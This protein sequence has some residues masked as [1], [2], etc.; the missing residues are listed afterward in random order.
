[1]EVNTVART[2]IAALVLVVTPAVPGRSAPKA[3]RAGPDTADHEGVKALAQRLTE[4]EGQLAELT[5]PD[6]PRS[7]WV[8]CAAG[9]TVGS[10][11]A[12]AARTAGPLA[13]TIKGLCTEHVVITRDDTTLQGANPGDGLMS[14]EGK[15]PAPLVRV[16]GAQRTILQ[17]LALKPLAPDDGVELDRGAVVT[18]SR[19]VIDDAQHALLLGEATIAE[20]EDS[21]FSNSHASQVIVRGGHLRL[22]RSTIA[23]GAFTGVSVMGGGTLECGQNTLQGNAYW[24]LSVADNASAT[25]LEG[26]EIEENAVGVFVATGGTVLV[27]SGSLIGN[28][29]EEGIR[30]SEGSRLT[31]GGGVIVE[32]NAGHGVF[33]TGGSLVSAF[34]ANIRNNQG[35]GIYLTDTS[36]ASGPQLDAH[37]R[38]QRGLGSVLRGAS[39]RRPGAPARAAGEDGHRQYGGSDQLPPSWNPR[40]DS[41]NQGIV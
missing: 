3:L 31:L 1:M 16:D 39:R 34:E 30:V 21:E 8:D 40:P 33:V 9:E 7:I 14:P 28:N 26:T 38:R 10:V 12:R 32:N 11:L 19:L 2:M 5:T 13:I 41:V 15:E 6:A 36:V 18:A 35:S 37:H 27:T 25:V 29:R 4:L 23:N 24:G 20:V 22:F 17:Q